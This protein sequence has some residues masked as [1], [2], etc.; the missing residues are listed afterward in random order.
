MWTGELA[1]CKADFLQV[2]PQMGTMV[3]TVWDGKRTGR[4]DMK[5]TMERGVV[6]V[7]KR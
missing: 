6:T 7:S 3:R 2:L 5:K 1:V 4:I